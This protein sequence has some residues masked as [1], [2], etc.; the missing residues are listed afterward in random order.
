MG[1]ENG[2]G[3]ASVAKEAWPTDHKNARVA[4]VSE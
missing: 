1:R 2:A 4:A 3:L